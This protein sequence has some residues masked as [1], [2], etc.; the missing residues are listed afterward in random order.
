MCSNLFLYNLQRHSDHHANPMRRYQT[1]RSMPEAP[2]LPAGYAVLVL[3]SLVP[4]LWRRVMDRRVLE[5]YGYDLTRINIE[6]R[7]EAEILAR[8]PSVT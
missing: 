5:H 4:P 6:P 2:Q 7:K 8:Y 1:L 3:V